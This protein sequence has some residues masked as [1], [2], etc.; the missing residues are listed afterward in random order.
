[1]MFSVRVLEDLQLCSIVIDNI[2]L[3]NLLTVLYQSLYGYIFVYTYTE[4]GFNAFLSYIPSILS[5]LAHPQTI[6]AWNC[7][8]QA[9]IST[10]TSCIFFDL[11]I[12]YI[13]V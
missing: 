7:K 5:L 4:T 12:L 1:M 11:Q 9:Y 8:Y 10:E 2:K 6:Y 3:Y 13:T